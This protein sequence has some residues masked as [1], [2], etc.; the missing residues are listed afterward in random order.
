MRH[1]ILP[2]LLGLLL[3]AAC[4]TRP[5]PGVGLQDARMAVSL[6][7]APWRSVGA[8]VTAVG[9]R[10]TG[11]LVGP[12]VVLTAA[13]CVVHPRTGQQLEAREVAVVLGLSPRDPG[14][15]AGVVQLALGPG[16]RARPGPTPDPAVPPDSDWA[17]LLLEPAETVP[18]DHVL[19][20]APGFA[21]AGT[22]L[23]FGGYQADRPNQL[24][25]DLTCQVLGYGRA[26][27]GQLMLRHSCNATSGSSGGPL[28]VRLPDGVWTVAGVGSMA[29]NTDAGGWAVP[30]I[31]IRRA[32]EA[33]AAKR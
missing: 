19:P 21:R 17:L 26:P 22:R 20:V 9:G 18:S 28:L 3:L 32:L 8:V 1:R 12:R 7:E 29:L 30:G 11:A 13:H 31:T 23:A 27:T 15:R 14:R 24:V 10:C 25:A 16:F 2:L 5:L 6:E 4:E 33:A